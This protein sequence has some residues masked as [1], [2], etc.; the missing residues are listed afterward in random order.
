MSSSKSSHAHSYPRLVGDVGGTNARFALE[1]APSQ[2]EHIRVYP[3]QAYDTFE[4]AVR[5]YL[6]DEHEKIER[7]HHA[8]I[9]IA[10]P[11]M[12]DWIQMTNH[13]WQFSVEETRQTLDWD[14]F[15]VL[16]DFAVLARSLPHLPA[17]DIQQV[18]G[19][20]S[21]I[22][23]QHAPLA[24]L[25][26][27]TGLGVSGLFRHPHG[28]IP[29]SGEGGH[30]NFAP[31]SDEE[32]ELLSFAWKKFGDHVSVERFL[33]G[34]GLMLLEEAIAHSTNVAYPARSAS[35]IVR[36]A[37]AGD[38]EL[39]SHVIHTFCAMLG[40]VAANLA[41]TL[42]ASGVYIGG[43]IVPKLGEAFAAS[44]FRQRFEQKG[45]FRPYLQRIPVFV[46][47]SAFPALIG[48][49]AALREAL[50]EH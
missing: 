49:A 42:G 37:L 48:A 11:V 17:S 30:V 14:H 28:V 24:L 43:G 50:G 3:C 7:I 22:D 4:A 39:A 21:S 8:A 25:G 13:H 45:R 35:E 2:I 29:I 1:T 26:A 10:N 44:P 20:A 47:H 40:T 5:Q 12:G 18:G 31:S 9:G 46:I 27:G 32:F 16:N 38:C 34:S 33:S 19:I 15:L 23:D 36:S 6:R 41:L